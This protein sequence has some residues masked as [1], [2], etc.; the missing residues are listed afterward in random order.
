M[1]EHLHRSDNLLISILENRKQIEFEVRFSQSY[2][3]GT[4]EA[5][6]PRCQNPVA[7]SRWELEG[8]DGSGNTVWFT[9]SKTLNGEDS[10]GD[11]MSWTR[12]VTFGDWVEEEES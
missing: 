8:P 6:C 5:V 9:C 1:K 7:P 3:R 11:D 2:A 12:R 4:C 10:C